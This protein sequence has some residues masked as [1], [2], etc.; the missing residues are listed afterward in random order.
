[1]LKVEPEGLLLLVGLGSMSWVGLCC[2]R[3]GEVFIE[4]GNYRRSLKTSLKYLNYFVR[5][6]GTGYVRYVRWT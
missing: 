6:G 2:G 1:M 3:G 4:M 5:A